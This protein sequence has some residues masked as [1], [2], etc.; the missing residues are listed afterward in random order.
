MRKNEKRNIKWS[1]KASE[2]NGVLMKFLKRRRRKGLRNGEEEA[3][4]IGNAKNFRR[5]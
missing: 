4:K 3:A 5:T 1:Q 2:L